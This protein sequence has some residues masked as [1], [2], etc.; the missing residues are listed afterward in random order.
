MQ[1]WRGQPTLRTKNKRK[2]AN[3][4]HCKVSCLWINRM[5]GTNFWVSHKKTTR[6]S[7]CLAN[8]PRNHIVRSLVTIQENGNTKKDNYSNFV[9]NWFRINR[10]RQSIWNSLLLE[11]YFQWTSSPTWIS[12]SEWTR[13]QLRVTFSTQWVFVIQIYSNDKREILAKNFRCPETDTRPE[14]VCILVSCRG[15]R[16]VNQPSITDFVIM[17]SCRKPEAK[18]DRIISKVMSCEPR[19]D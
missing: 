7:F 4:R 19:Q 15:W 16:Y 14:V 6:N 13:N 11:E 2:W 1:S 10:E 18:L 8:R 17:S 12:V 3:W 9:N 5:K